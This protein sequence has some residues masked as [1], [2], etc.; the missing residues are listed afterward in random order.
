MFGNAPGIICVDADDI[1]DVSESLPSLEFPSIPTVVALDLF[2]LG[3]GGKTFPGSS[4][5]RF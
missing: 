4:V 2:F 1:E 5:R 3:S